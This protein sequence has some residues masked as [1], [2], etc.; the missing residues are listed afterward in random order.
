MDEKDL[1]FMEIKQAEFYAGTGGFTGLR[2]K[3]EDYAH[4][5]LRRIMPQEEPMRYISIA[6]N[7][8]EEIAIVKDLADL[9]TAQREVVIRDLDNRYYCPTSL[10]VT[11]VQ[12]KLGYVY[13]GM[14]L[15]NKNGVEYE[16]NCA[17][18]DVSRNIRMLSDNAVII[19]DV[20]GNRYTAPDLTKLSRASMRKLD[21]YLF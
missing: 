16:K 5:I 10:D 4:V 18:K 13:I 1:N 6:N 11:G 21:S 14:R 8:N 7:E 12:D 20:D 17:V 9:P 3:G 19:F 2:Y 15:L